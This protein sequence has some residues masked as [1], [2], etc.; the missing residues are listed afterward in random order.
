M[1]SIY[2][3]PIYF[4]LIA[5][6]AC[7][8]D[9]AAEMKQ[10]KR[11]LRSSETRVKNQAALRAASFGKAGEPLVPELIGLLRDPNGGVRSSAA[12]ALREIDN[13]AARA[14][15]ANEK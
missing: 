5:L 8:G 11:D 1:K 2:W 14:A 13:E 9:S 15:L 6:T 7:S 12:Y 4:L 3:H 10:L